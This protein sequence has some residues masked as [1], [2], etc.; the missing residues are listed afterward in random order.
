VRA[1]GL[2]LT[3]IA[4]MSVVPVSFAVAL[5][6][7]AL[8]YEVAPSNVVDGRLALV[9]VT[10]PYTRRVNSG[11]IAFSR[12]D[13]QNWVQARRR[14][15]DGKFRNKLYYP[16]QPGTQP[17][18]IPVDHLDPEEPLK[19]GDLEIVRTELDLGIVEAPQ[20]TCSDTRPGKVEELTVDGWKSVVKL[21]VPATF[22][23]LSADNSVL[24]YVKGPCKSSAPP[25]RSGG[26]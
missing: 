24:G 10:N 6:K 15:A 14:S 9:W 25:T 4:S 17:F 8:I 12:F 2:C 20:L 13:G 3:L 19:L 11:I 7:D 23:V 26:R 5:D 1:S 22:R 18:F 16:V 21:S